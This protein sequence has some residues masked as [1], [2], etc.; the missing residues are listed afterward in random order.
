MN[1][2]ITGGAG[3]IGSALSRALSKKFKVIVADDLSTG[4][5]EKL[6]V[7]RQIEFRKINVNDCI[8]VSN[9]F[10]EFKFDYVFHF[11]AMVGVKRTTE[12]PLSV[13]KDIDGVKN[14]LHNSTLSGVKRVFYASSSEVY[15]EPVEVPLKEDTSPLNSVVPYAVTKNIGECFCRAYSKEKGL[16]YTIFRFFNTYGPG[17]SEDFVIMN[18]LRSA[19]S[20]K[21]LEIFGDGTQTRTFCFITDT[22]RFIERCLDELAFEND[23]VNVGSE[24]QY[25]INELARIVLE[26]TA[27][28]SSIKHIPARL[29]GDMVR[30]Q[31]DNTK[32]MKL[33]DWTPVDLVG[34]LRQTLEIVNR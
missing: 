25:S 6:P 3:N 21:D 19:L 2:L 30:R 29:V 12:A 14:I 15:G 31:P 5:L 27:S 8:D 11:A 13:L 4:K 20:G 1:I 16:P 18:F 26:L 28:K 10:K 33:V 22:V 7:N 34:G 9:L 24:L 32:M 17:Q 23:V